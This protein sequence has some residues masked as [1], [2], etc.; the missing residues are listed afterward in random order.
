MLINAFQYALENRVVAFNRV[1]GD[2]GGFDVG[3]AVWTSFVGSFVEVANVFVLAMVHGVM[4]GEVL[5]HF[6]VPFAFV[7]IDRGFV[8][9]VGADDRGNFGK[10]V[11]V[12]RKAPRRAATVN[13]REHD[14]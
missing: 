1:G 12:D 5:G 7:G 8:V 14:V 10:R 2:V 6:V 13:E 4:A 9:H 11:R 3:L